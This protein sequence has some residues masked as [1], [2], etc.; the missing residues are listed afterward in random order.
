[1]KKI[2][3]FVCLL[4]FSHLYSQ[5]TQTLNGTSIWSLAKDYEG[6][7]YAGSLGS[8]SALY[9][10]TNN[11][12]NWVTLTSGNS[13]TIFSIAIDVTGNIFAANFSNGL[14]KSTNGGVNFVTMSLSNFG[15][16]N[17]NAVACGSNGMVYVGT[18]GA[19]FFRSTDFGNSF[20]PTG[21]SGV[22]VITIAVD[23]YNPAIVYAGV[24]STTSGPNGFYRSI[25]YGLSFSSN[26]NPNKNIYGI[27]Q[28]SQTELYSVSTTTGGP[29]D[30]STDGGLSWTTVSTGYIA[31]GIC[32]GVI[33][34]QQIF[35]SG[36]SGISSTMNNGLSFI[37][38]GLSSSATPIL[39]KSTR[40]YAGLSG[41]SNG[42]VWIRD[43][44]VGIQNT[45]E[46]AKEFSLSQNYPNPFNPSTKI[47]FQIPNAEFA[48]LKVFDLLGRVIE[49]LV[50]ENLAKGSF[51]V[52]WDASA[53]PS[54]IYF[55]S[56]SAGVYTE[57]RKMILLK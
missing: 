25:D 57:T 11:A 14:L 45:G 8:A 2:I 30:R 6:N 26:L 46:L 32:D 10:T 41:S 4:S 51:E 3:I 5:W 55:Y 12:N 37:G 52:Q 15:G 19:G 23:V 31:R 35:I 50:N 7:I 53:Y 1:M 40:I 16:S 43:Y 49:S 9:K 21:L 38:E 44:P 20:F 36:N 47:K 13:Q 28:R 27:L 56:L 22:Q 17:L 34:S 48:Q 54:G 39:R 24:T 42:G 29:F 18:N 33:A